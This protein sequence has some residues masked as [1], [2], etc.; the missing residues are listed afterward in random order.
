MRA[1]TMRSSSAGAVRRARRRL[2]AAAVAAFAVALTGCASLGDGTGSGS[3]GDEPATDAPTTPTGTAGTATPLLQIEHEGGFVMMG[4]DVASVPDLTVYRDGR[5]INHGPQ[6][7]IYPP[8]ALP[9]L[10]AQDLS[11]QDLETLVAA[12]RDAGLLGDVD[13]GQPAIAD[14]PTTY[15]TLTVDG[16]THVHAA[17]ALG[18]TEG[19][20]EGVPGEEID[21]PDHGLTA[22]QREARAALSGFITEAHELV[23]ATGTGEPYAIP[24]FAVQAQPA[25]DVDA[26]A[27]ADEGDIERQVLPWP[28]DISLADAQECLVVHG[29]AVQTLLETLADA[30]FST[31]YEQDGVTYD[32][33]FRPLLPHEETCAD[34]V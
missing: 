17:E 3:P 30:S 34:A 16:Q 5:A 26:G 4:Y 7:A 10:L 8:P 27:S 31:Q 13:Y 21:E 28:L 6:I 11:E 2:A 14:A 25:P 1:Q 29:D 15:V 12:A 9:N 22:E 18:V 33:W 24:A 32:V 20:L 23:G 19:G